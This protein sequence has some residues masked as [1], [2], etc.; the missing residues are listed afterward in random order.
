MP[1]YGSTS[2]VYATLGEFL[3]QMAESGGIGRRLASTGLSLRFELTNPSASIT[4]WWTGDRAVVEFGSSEREATLILRLSSSAAHSM[5][6]GE[7][8]PWGLLERGE[9]ELI[10][11]VGSIGEVWPAVAF[12]GPSRYEA[13]INEAS[14]G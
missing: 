7:S 14:A 2:A 3:L 8:S 12:A 1:P 11:E 5:F 13:I 10:G 4:L 9:L 6:S